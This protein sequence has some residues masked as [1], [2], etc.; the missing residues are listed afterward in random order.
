MQFME[1]FNC[2]KKLKATLRLTGKN[3][4]FEPHEDNSISVKDYDGNTLQEIKD[5]LEFIK[6]ACQFTTD[7]W[8][9]CCSE[10]ANKIG[11]LISFEDALKELKSGKCIARFNYS[12]DG[13]YLAI[14]PSMPILNMDEMKDK[15]SEDII[16]L[17]SCEQI[18]AFDIPT[19]MEY[20][21]HYKFTFDDIMAHDWYVLY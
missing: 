15:C 18:V 2:A 9:L 8:M 14:K 17:L 10:G 13:V 4:V 20:N 1:A 16:K 11:K 6:I 12:W 7:D 3:Y 5:P 21:D 19:G